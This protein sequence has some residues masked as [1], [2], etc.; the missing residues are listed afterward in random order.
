M[1]IL[2]E[3]VVPRVLPLNVDQYHRMIALGIL[4]EG[5]PLEL[6]D[7][8]LIRKDRADA[9]GDP[10]SHGPRHA[11]SLKRLQRQ[12]RPVEDWGF[13]L[14]CQLP[15]TLA[16]VQEPEPDLAIV[17]GIPEDYLERHPGPADILA[18]AEVADS[19]LSY[20]RTT[21]QRLYALA[22][23]TLYWI[24]NLVNRQVEVYQQP[25]PVA[26]IY[27]ARTDYLPGQSVSLKVGPSQE[28][29]LAVS[30]LVLA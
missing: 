19:S 1:S 22:G 18:L 8:I 3:A 14:H 27:Q 17:R 15:V 23:I 6:I 30:E 5:D 13:H 12:F 24:I 21:K 20:D 26:G 4:R 11:L 16:V 2:E 25:D 29:T 9:G 10:M 28:I 7:G